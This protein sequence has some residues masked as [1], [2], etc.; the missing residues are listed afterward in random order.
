MHCTVLPGSMILSSLLAI[1]WTN[2]AKSFLCK[3]RRR[4]SKSPWAVEVV[5]P[6]VAADKFYFK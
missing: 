3:F 4:E 6:T 5:G 2:S 1:I